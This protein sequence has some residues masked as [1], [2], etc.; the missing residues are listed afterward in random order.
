M[1]IVDMFF[2]VKKFFLEL[3]ISFVLPVAANEVVVSEHPNKFALMNPKIIVLNVINFLKVLKGYL[4]HQIKA[5]F[6]PLEHE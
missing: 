3:R 5:V 6:I 4:L 2:I 1:K